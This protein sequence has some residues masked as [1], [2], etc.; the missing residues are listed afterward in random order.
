METVAKRICNHLIDLNLLVDESV[1]E[2][3]DDVDELPI[4]EVDNRRVYLS[5]QSKK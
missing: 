3:D 1:E 4:E 5:N 2:E